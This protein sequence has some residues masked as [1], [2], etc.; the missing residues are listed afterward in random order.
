[1]NP[2]YTLLPMLSLASRELKRFYRQRSRIIGTLGTPLLF[3]FFLGSG[4]G[5]AFPAPEMPGGNGYMEYFYPGNVMLAVLFTAIFSTITIIEDRKEGFLQSTLSAPV[6][7]LGLVGGKVL[8]GALIAMVQGTLFLILA[9]IAGIYLNVVG[10]LMALLA[11]AVTALALTALGFFF[12]W[13]FDSVQGFHSVMNLILFPMWLLC[14]AFFPIS[15]APAFLRPI[16]AINPLTYGM[17]A[18]QNGLYF[19]KS[20]GWISYSV[21]LGI[22]VIFGAVF[23]GACLAV[24]GRRRMEVM[25]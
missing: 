19:G 12:A 13:W 20:E 15:R 5:A 2:S 17:A 10:F 22:T 7:R 11:L 3:W 4:L 9:P 25:A 24:V 14:G 8:G 16:M 18:L 1:M 6:S 23:L 21:A